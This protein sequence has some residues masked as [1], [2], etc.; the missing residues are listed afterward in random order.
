M[1]TAA[2]HRPATAQLLQPKRAWRPIA[3]LTS[4]DQKT[5][6]ETIG[7]DPVGRVIGHVLPGSA[8]LASAAP[9][10]LAALHRAREFCDQCDTR[11]LVTL[12]VIDAAIA[13]AEGRA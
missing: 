10:L 6:I 3:G 12:R 8:A 2:T 4:P 1:P 11:P 9:D 7:E 13:K 5:L